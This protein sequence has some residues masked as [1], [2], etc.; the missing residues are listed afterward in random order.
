MSC[1][2]GDCEGNYNIDAHLNLVKNGTVTEGCF[3]YKSSDGETIPE[4]PSQCEDGSEYK[5]YYSQNA[6]LANVNEEVFKEVVILA[7]DQLVTQG[8]IMGSFNVYEDF[9]VFGTDHEKCKNDVYTYDGKSANTGGHAITIVGYGILKNKIYWLLQNSWGDNWCDNG[10]IK[11]EIGN[12]YGL[13][14]SE[15]N[16]KP[17]IVNPY[18]YKLI[19]GI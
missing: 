6:Y 10:F 19:F 14:F 8:P 13:T 11:M 7:M 12:F 9:D 5:K 18:K 17:D 3:P 4:C 2:K 15:P 16:I 1:Y